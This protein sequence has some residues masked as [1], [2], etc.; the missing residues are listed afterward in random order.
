[1]YR[2]HTKI[3]FN[4]KVEVL[5]TANNLQIIQLSE[6]LA[7]RNVQPNNDEEENDIRDLKSQ[8]T[9]KDMKLNKCESCQTTFTQR[10]A[11]LKHIRAKHEGIKYPCNFCD[12]KAAE[13]CQVKRHEESIHEGIRYSCNQCKFQATRAETIKNHTP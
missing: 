7:E 6:V 10:S 9:D 5:E 2:G 12:F 8:C 3:P 13:K 4:D 1:M 11:M